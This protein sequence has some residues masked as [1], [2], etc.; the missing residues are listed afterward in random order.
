MENL[1]PISYIPPST[2]FKFPVTGQS[3]SHS[4]QLFG[5]KNILTQSV[6]KKEMLLNE[7]DVRTFDLD[8]KSF[9]KML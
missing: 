5:Q 4:C 7:T 9:F 3:R 6:A 1:D 8:Q 2:L